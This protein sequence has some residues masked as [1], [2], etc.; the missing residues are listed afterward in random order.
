MM[1]H[2]LANHEGA[3]LIIVGLVG[4]VVLALVVPWMF[5]FMDWYTTKIERWLGSKG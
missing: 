2:G 5:I 3:F 4:L 1:D